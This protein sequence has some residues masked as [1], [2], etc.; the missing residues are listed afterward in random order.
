MQEQPHYLLKATENGYKIEQKTKKT[1]TPAIPKDRPYSIVPYETDKSEIKQR[2][3]MEEGII[4]I[5]PSSIIINGSSGSGKSQLLISL[6]CRE[7][8]WGESSEL[9]PSE[10]Q[11][12]KLTQMGEKK[13]KNHYFDKLYLFSPT[14]GTMDDLC[15][16]LLS[17]TPLEKKDIFNTFDEST[18]MKILDDQE[19]QID[20]VG[21]AKSPRICIILDDIQSNAKFLR[22]ETIKKIFIANRH[23]NTTTILCSQSFKLTPRSCR[24]QANNIMIFP[25]SN[26]E[27]K[28]LLEEFT[29]GGLTVKEMKEI[30]DEATGDRH[31]FL[32]INKRHPPRTR[33]RKNL[34]EILELTGDKFKD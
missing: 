15:K 11:K 33:F 7:C 4:P 21:F 3:I 5:H 10:Y 8:F 32:H 23:L 28:I 27:V 2:K 20:E 12:A 26:S 25:A 29:P 24:L 14:A 6:M 1:K 13:K 9:P 17:H 18:L 16:H 31:S 30:F 19:K 22:S 34:D